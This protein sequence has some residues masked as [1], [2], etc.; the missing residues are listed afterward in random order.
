MSTL[1]RREVIKDSAVI[2][3]LMIFAVLLRIPLLYNADADFSS[4]EAVNALVAKHILEGKEFPTHVWDSSYIGILEGLTAIPF[5]MVLGLSALAFKCATLFYFCLLLVVTY[6]LTKGLAGRPTAIIATML[7]ACSSPML[8]FW[9]VNAG[10]GTT[11]LIFFGTLAFLM[12]QQYAEADRERTS[13]LFL[14]AFIIGFALYTY[15]LFSVYAMAL[16]LYYVLAAPWWAAI[17]TGKT[18]PLGQ[19]V[20]QGL[21]RC[22]TTRVDG[23]G[24]STSVAVFVAGFMLGFSPK[25]YQLILG[26]VSSKKPLYMLAGIAK[27][28]ANFH[29]LLSECL[30]VLLGLNPWRRSGVDRWWVD[31]WVG[32]ESPVLFYWSFVV[33]AMIVMACLGTIWTSRQALLRIA[34]LRPIKMALPALMVVLVIVTLS[35]FVFTPNPQDV[36]S[37]RYL[38]PVYTSLPFFI[39]SWLTRWKKFHRFAPFLGVLLIVGF[40]LSENIAWNMRQG[41]LS[42]SGHLQRVATPMKD[43]IAYLREQGVRGGYGSYWINYYATFLSSEHIIIAPYEDWDRYP[44]YSLYVKSLSSPAYIFSNDELSGRYLEQ[45]LISRATPYVKKT[46]GN[47]I[48]LHAPEKQPFYNY[49][50]EPTAA[51]LT[52]S[53]LH[54]QFLKYEIPRT[55]KAGQVARVPLLVRN[56]GDQRW[57]AR[58][59]KDARYRVSVAYHWANMDG[60]IV[61]FNEERTLFDRDVLP[62]DQAELLATIKAPG[63]QGRY[64]LIL[65][66]VQEWVTWF[67]QVGGGMVTKDVQILE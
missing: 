19:R 10:G 63:R 53:G 65:T 48:V 12:L 44:P 47:Y 33:L 8:V 54:A 22:A 43:L 57:S 49:L 3:A 50:T 52:P 55:M 18:E 27:I 38:L 1:P 36:L 28:Q 11:L 9:S 2:M 35:A 14:L 6:F 26:P 61:I 42:S 13:L 5:V 25:L 17:R 62:G 37:N 45:F 64:R 66:L 41:Y 21:V 46:F 67:D 32:L 39:G 20:T 23:A 29:L 34:W 56:A 40:Y 58:G 16:A 51:P 7:L 59:W 31:R 4:D 15:E 60:Q 24:R 30:P